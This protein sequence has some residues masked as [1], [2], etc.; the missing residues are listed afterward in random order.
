[1]KIAEIKINTFWSL[2]FFLLF[3]VS[4]LTKFFGI[5]MFAFSSFCNTEN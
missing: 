2:V 1:M 4:T 5:Y 3:L